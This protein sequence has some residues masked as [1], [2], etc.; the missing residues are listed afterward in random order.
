MFPQPGQPEF[1]TAGTEKVRALGEHWF[2]AE[3]QA[4][5]VDMPMQSLMTLGFDPAKGKVI[6]TWIDSVSGFM[7]HLE[8]TLDASGTVLTLTAEGP[9]MAEPG[10]L[11][12]YRDVIEFKSTNHR[13]VTSSVL[14]PD[15]TWRAFG[16]V[17][18]KRVE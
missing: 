3:G 1:Q 18:A 4:T 10:K 14:Q 9:C 15:G 17:E 8:G 6:G 11:T 5:L 12:K 13:V 16:S 2:I 7:W